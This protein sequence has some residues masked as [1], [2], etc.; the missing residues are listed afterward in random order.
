[1]AARAFDRLVSHCQCT[2]RHGKPLIEDP[3]VQHRLAELYTDLEAV[4]LMSYWVGSMHTRGLQPQH[5]TS[6][7]VLVKRE[8]IRAMDAYGAELLGPH[9]ELSRG[10]A[11][12]PA[13]GEIVHD[14]LDRMYFSFAAGG[15]DITRQVI[16]TRGLGLPRG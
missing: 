3:V 11:L 12:A 1:M 13:G 6:L 7:S 15:F 14:Y 5:E 8:T 9:A 16:A 10:E 4:R 2:R